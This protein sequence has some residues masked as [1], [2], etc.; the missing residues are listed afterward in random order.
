MVPLKDKTLEQE[1]QAIR[2]KVRK[3]FA[4]QFV[5]AERKNGK[6]TV[7][8]GAASQQELYRGMAKSGHGG[9]LRHSWIV[10]PMPQPKERIDATTVKRI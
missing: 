3:Q 2:A 9:V 1:L 4:G 8:R 6:I 5:L 10:F 7:L